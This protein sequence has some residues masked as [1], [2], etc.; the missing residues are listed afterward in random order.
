VSP[1]ASPPRSTTLIGGGPQCR[2]A[3]MYFYAAGADLLDV[4]LL[5][6]Q[7]TDCRLLEAE[8]QID[9]PLRQL[10]TGDIGQWIGLSRSGAYVGLALWS[11]AMRQQIGIRTVTLQ[12]REG[13][14]RQSAVGWG[15]IHLQ[16]MD[17]RG[18]KLARS[19]VTANSESR[20]RRWA[21]TE[22]ELGPVDAWDWSAV[23]RTLRRI[24]RLIRSRLVVGRNDGVPM[25]RGAQSA[26]GS[27]VT[28]MRL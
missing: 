8:S 15:L 17:V 5:V 11:P 2:F 14:V 16:L 6:L 4:A 24:E 28:L 9:Q 21:D 13:G 19:R 10:D 22:M 1:W 7:E 3:Q 18:G 23:E 20:A 26:F 12:T 27:G 25:L